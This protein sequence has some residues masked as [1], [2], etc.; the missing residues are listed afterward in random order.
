MEKPPFQFNLRYV[1][2]WA[3][4]VAVLAAGVRV[5]LPALDSFIVALSDAVE[6]FTD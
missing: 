3:T 5:S 4:V 6:R 1:F 2:W